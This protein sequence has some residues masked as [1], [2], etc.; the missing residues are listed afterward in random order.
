MKVAQW[1]LGTWIFI[2]QIVWP[3]SEIFTFSSAPACPSQPGTHIQKPGG[4]QVQLASISSRPITLNTSHQ[5]SATK[6][7]SLSP[8]HATNKEKGYQQLLRPVVILPNSQFILTLG[9]KGHSPFPARL[10]IRLGLELRRNSEESHHPCPTR[11][12]SKSQI[13]RF[14]PL[15]LSG[16][17]RFP[18]RRP[19]SQKCCVEVQG[20]P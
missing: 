12:V 9:F 11:K 2:G 14:G 16:A 5:I 15:A 3:A 4:L 13:R 17:S 1:L 6:D 8:K 20:Q 19:L 10:P 7:K 18:A